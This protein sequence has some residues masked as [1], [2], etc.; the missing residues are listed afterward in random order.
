M[1]EWLIL[2]NVQALGRAGILDI[3]QDALLALLGV[4]QWLEDR[5]IQC[6][7]ATVVTPTRSLS[8]WTVTL[9]GRTFAAVR[10]RC[11]A[12]WILDP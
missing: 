9:W 5:I 2:E 12:I 11:S 6:G 7:T 1:L 8:F 10:H 4:C 3:A